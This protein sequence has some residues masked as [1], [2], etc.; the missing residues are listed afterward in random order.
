M[1]KIAETYS[2]GAT[3]NLTVEQLYL[4]M[5]DMYRDLAIAINR[6]P[7]VYFR[8]TDGQSTDSFLSNGDLNVNENTNKV[9]ML[10][11]RPTANT[12]GWTT[13]S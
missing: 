10:T 4:I 11:N 7:D 13:L 9:E 2:A 3:E 8:T 5:L 1:A 12:V 6:K